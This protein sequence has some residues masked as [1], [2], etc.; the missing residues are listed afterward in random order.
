[1]AS[2]LL[3]HKIHIVYN[4]TDNAIHNKLILSKI[5]H[6]FHNAKIIK[7]NTKIYKFKTLCS[8]YFIKFNKLKQNKHA[9]IAIHNIDHN[10]ITFISKWYYKLH[11]NTSSIT[12]ILSNSFTHSN[13]N[14][15]LLLLHHIIQFSSIKAI[16][17]IHL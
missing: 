1:M 14:Y 13:T 8:N 7:I 10:T 2:T 4:E 12:L 11:N 5:H 6:Y 3:Q 16:K 17:I 15:Y 9:Y